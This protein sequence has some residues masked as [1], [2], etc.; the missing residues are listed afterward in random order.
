MRLRFPM[1][2]R[3]IRFLCLMATLGMAGG[4][5]CSG[6]IQ[7]AGR[8]LIDLDAADFPPGGD[9][10][11][12]HSPGTGIPGYFMPRGTPT[13]QTVA[14]AT[15]LVFDGDGDCFVG[16][17]TTSAL[18]APGAAHSVEV[19]AYQGNVRDQESLV[20]W[21]KR[22]AADGAFAGFRYGAHPDFGAVARWRSSEAGFSVLPPPGKW[23]HLVFTYDG[24]RQAV[25]VDGKL[26]STKDAGLLDAQD[27]MPILLGAELRGDLQMEG[28]FTH[29][30]GALARLRIHGG[31]LGAEAVKANYQTEAPGFAGTSPKPL[32][33]P[34]Q[35]RFS[36]DAP[37]GPAADGL[38]VRDSIGGLAVIARGT[39]ARFTGQ[40][41]RLPGGSSSTQA[42]LDFP[43][44]LV[45]SQDNVTIEF[46]ETQ[47][48]PRDWSRI[49]SIGTCGG[50]E[51]KGPG[52]VFTG[53][54]ALTLFGNVGTVPL[55][56]FAR[57]EG[58]I[59]NGGPDRDPADS[60][61]SEMGV[62]FHQVVVYD[63]PLREW[64]WYRNGVL[65]EV[66]PDAEGPTTLD[67]VNVWFGRSEVSTDSNF[68]GVI[69]EVRFYSRTL[70]EAEILGSFQAGPGALNLATA[71]PALSW[72]PEDPGVH[73]FA[74]TPNTDNWG[75]GPGGPHPDGSGAT[76]TFAGNLSG[77]QQVNLEVP[78]T[79]GSLNLG[80][81]NAGGAFVLRAGASGALTLDAGR[82]TP[83]AV[84][85]LPHSPSNILDVP[86]T[87][88]SDA[89]LANLAEKPLFLGGSIRGR[90]VL[91]K[92]GPGPVVVTG[93]GSAFE[94]A[95]R[96]VAGDLVMGD[97][98]RVGLLSA[99]RFTLVDPGRLVVDR[100][101][102]LTISPKLD[103][104]GNFL[105]QGK[106]RLT[107]GPEAV[108]GTKGSLETV[109][110]AGP[111]VVEGRV[112][113]ARRLQ[114]CN[115][116][117]LA[118]NCILSLADRL[119]VGPQGG[120]QLV[121]RGQADVKT[122]SVVLGADGPK[123][124]VLRM[125]S[126]ALSFRELF[127]GRGASGSAVLLQTGGE[128]ANGSGG[129]DSRL[130]GGSEGAFQSWGAWLMA[131][132]SF[133]SEKSLQV[134][135]YGN[136][137]LSVNGG[138][139]EINGFVSVGRFCDDAGRRGHG[140]VD[141]KAGRLL[142]SGSDRL[143]LVGE[144]GTG[145]LN[146]R[147]SGEVR[148]ASS[149][150]I[151]AGTLGKAGTGTANLLEGG[152]L[153]AGGIGQFNQAKATGTLYLDGGLLLAAASNA[154]FLEGLDAT[155]IGPRGVKIDTN[156]FE[157]A[158]T[159]PLLQA[160]GQGLASIP[161]L[162]GG[163]GYLAPPLVEIEGG[164]ACAVAEL[165]DGSVARLV[166]TNPG[167]GYSMPPAV[168]I[169]GGGSGSGLLLG[170]P[171]LLP[172]RSGGLVKTG[173]G[174]LSLRGRCTYQ[175]ATVVE[176]GTLLAEGDLAS[177]TGEVEVRQDAVLGGSGTLGGGL[178]AE[179]GSTVAPGN[180][181]GTLAV[182][183]DARL[184]GTLV[185][186]IAATHASLLEVAGELDVDGA[187]LEIRGGGVDVVR[188]THI[189]ARYGSLKGRFAATAVPSGFTLDYHFGGLNQ[190]ALIPTAPPDEK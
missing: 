21:G 131:G 84:T 88:A 72:T 28:R 62:E 119:V 100:G 10:W 90:T 37:A 150:I 175:G 177:A 78:V 16:P 123:Q 55:N 120:G 32:V 166:V 56:R 94:G 151:G 104:N 64:R 148:C 22:Q 58:A 156:G 95:V 3:S 106:G 168:S 176:G 4:G 149:V 181:L 140:L 7:V 47:L 184:Q 81:R 146:V 141:V 69:R 44:R 164:G 154:R 115:E 35:H 163:A 74:N 85:Q 41:I 107:L 76:A 33:R 49:F 112:E 70:D 142:A 89:D 20:S 8:L 27:A 180:P 159:Q 82:T 48:E 46:W 161:V 145:T 71:A 36:F 38:V 57:F 172:N 169:R 39:E 124:S 129:E 153:F 9:H 53:G 19:W 134:G 173:A 93:D 40:G 59:L 122:R 110:G 86:L 190:I 1:E 185:V 87:L 66:I 178:R 91:S 31:V 108:I 109:E 126:G 127:I 102:D 97:S 116:V 68:C 152:T 60:P 52:G 51:I 187:R 65:M 77:D 130:G 45:S 54:E 125:E 158:I 14:G 17:A 6:E 98:K 26:D 147:G 12:Q 189:L 25:W 138:S 24:A 23:H 111:L 132:G 170:P 113:G 179:P 167:E 162:E 2:S 171:V 80:A 157:V 79:L 155:W 96:V 18:H 114:V 42:Y 121:V 73:S 128:L 43:N 182:G 144:E 165:E 5:L 63:K 188:T 50:G 103:G 174:T 118:N 136:G 139:I 11:P 186:S 133:H 117:V 92:T 99:A 30:S 137:L 183:G 135:A 34:P 61:D 67:D 143:L 105:H 160:M 75:S 29:F 13:R 101:D 15:A 83:A